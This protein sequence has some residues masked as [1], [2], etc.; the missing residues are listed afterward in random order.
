AQ[1]I[2]LARLMQRVRAAVRRGKLKRGVSVHD[3]VC[4]ATSATLAGENMSIDERRRKTADF[5]GALFGVPFEASDV[6]LADRLDPTS[7]A[8]RW[9]FEGAD[10]EQKSDSAWASIPPDALAD[11]DRVADDR[12]WE[13]FEEIAPSRI[14]SMAKTHGQEDRRAFLYHLLRGHPRF[15]WL[16]E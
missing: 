8:D 3:P 14:W 13:A 15:H 5:A 2:E 12:F 11:L 1:G 6:I 9:E 7:D 4:V 10:V 16:W